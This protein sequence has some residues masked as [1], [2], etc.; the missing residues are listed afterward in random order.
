M[1]D[2]ND[3]LKSFFQ[4]FKSNPFGPHRSSCDRQSSSVAISSYNVQTNIE[5]SDDELKRMKKPL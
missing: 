4:F 2:K 3:W 1:D 5:S